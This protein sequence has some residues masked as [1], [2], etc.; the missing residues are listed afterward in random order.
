[1]IRTKPFGLCLLTLLAIGSGLP[2]L[3]LDAGKVRLLGL[4]ASP[5]VLVYVDGQPAPPQ[6]GVLTL[7]PGWHELQVEDTEYGRVYRRM[8]EVQPRAFRS[9]TVELRSIRIMGPLVFPGSPRGPLGPP[10]PAGRPADPAALDL[11][12]EALAAL[13][14]EA[15]SNYLDEL[16]ARKVGVFEIHRFRGGTPLPD[17]YY[18]GGGFRPPGPAGRP[19]PP[20]PPG[21]PGNALLLQTDSG[22]SLLGEIQA[23]LHLPE[24]EEQL[25]QVEAPDGGLPNTRRVELYTPELKTRFEQGLQRLRSEYEKIPP[26]ELRDIGLTPPGPPGPHG[27]R[28]KDG[29]VPA[30]TPPQRL[31]REQTA[32]LLDLLDRDPAL[33]QRLQRLRADVGDLVE[34]TAEAQQQALRLKR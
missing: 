30:G 24:L 26:E 20:G 18:Y 11:A 31:S 12:P 6:E 1:M 5:K 2:A 22:G 9:L 32:Q 17:P 27:R 28:G 33:Q 3:A 16:E 29:Q 13:F 8:V 4:S 14:Q 7:P 19:G 23:R 34:W 15:L 25:R 21:V 10:G